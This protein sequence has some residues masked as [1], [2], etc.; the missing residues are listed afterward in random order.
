MNDSDDDDDKKIMYEN[1]SDNDV[2]YELWIGSYGDAGS[3]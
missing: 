1:E 3:M 2:V